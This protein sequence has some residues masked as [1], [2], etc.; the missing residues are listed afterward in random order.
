MRKIIIAVLAFEI[1]L[2]PGFFIVFNSVFS[3]ENLYA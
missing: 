3:G 1:G 2:F